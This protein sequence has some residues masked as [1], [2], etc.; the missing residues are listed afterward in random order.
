MVS[1]NSYVWKLLV[2]PIVSMIFATKF[3][4]TISKTNNFH[5]FLCFEASKPSE[6]IVP[7]TMEI[8]E[9]ICSTNSFHDFCYQIH[10]NYQ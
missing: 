6:A 9:S 4:E 3:M 1:I 5:Y 8:M 7:E 10:G 2:E